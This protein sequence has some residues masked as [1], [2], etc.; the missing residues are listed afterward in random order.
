MFKLN[1]FIK[2]GLYSRARPGLE[3][4]FIEHLPSAQYTQHICRPFPISRS[5]DELG[6]EK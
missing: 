6:I 5:E 4:N 2:K 3:L 1:T